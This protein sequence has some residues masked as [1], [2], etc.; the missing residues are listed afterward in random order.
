MK[1]L[2]MVIAETLR[3]YPPASRLDRVASN[4]FEYNGIRIKRGDIIAV[5]IYALHHDPNIYPQ[6]EQ[7][8]PERFS[9]D[10]KRT[11]T[12]ETYMPFGAGPRNCLGMR[13]AL[14]EM[15]ILLASLLV[16]YRFEKC[17]KTQVSSDFKLH[18]LI[19]YKL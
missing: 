15:K 17:E 19:K 2:D 13:F 11:R 10:N 16:K 6:P 4:D 8:R 7:F 3:M 12:N 1:Y 5:A 18:Y 14:L 9:E